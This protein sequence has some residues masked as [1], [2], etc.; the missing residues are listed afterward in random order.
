MSKTLLAG[1]D[2]IEWGWA[3]CTWFPAIRK[4]SRKYDKT[5][6][7]CK[8]SNRFLYEDFADEFHYY[9]KKGVVGF[10]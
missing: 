9:D 8:E 10:F 3:L 6:I 7:V 5:I 4:L 1:H 2:N